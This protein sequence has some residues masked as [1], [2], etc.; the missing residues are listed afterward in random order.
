M[1]CRIC[2]GETRTVLD[3]GA[4]AARQ[5]AEAGRRRPRE[6]LPARGRVLPRLRQPAAHPLRRRRRTSTTTIS[7][8]RR[9]R[10]RSR[11]TASTS[12]TT[13]RRRATSPDDAFLLEFG[14]NIGHFL[15][16]AQ[17]RV[18]R[19]LG[20]DPAKAIVEMANARGVPTV[21]DYFGPEVA[22]AT[23]AEH[24]RAQVVAGR[25]CAAHNA[26]PHALVTGARLALAPG[27][28]FVM[29][30]A[31]GLN[32]ILHGE[33]G[34]IYHEHM[35]YYTARSGAAALRRERA[36]A[37]R[38]DA[39]RHPR[40]LDG[41]LR[42]AAGDPPGAL[43]RRG[44]DRA[45]EGDPLG[46]AARPAAGDAR[47]LA[48]RDPGAARPLPGDRP[49]GLDVRRQRQGRDLRQRRRHRRGATSPSAPIRPR[50][51]SAASCPAPASRSAPRPRRSTPAPTT[52]W[53]PPGTTAT[54]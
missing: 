24:G 18:G 34:Q 17:T 47:A 6:A 32:T 19:V 10:R 28:V 37:R 11:R 51:R 35:Y 45:R 33:I 29:E 7:T 41:V 12:S 8:S 48:D 46:R 9:P 25:H 13:C 15:K 26:D 36:R 42:R 27:G 5:P 23:V 38:P 39:D 3:L 21:C 22:K 4:D 30:N 1:T 40:R 31:Y 2:R 20:I 54:S 43:D 52:T 53:S 49:L 50:R 44:D 16:Y 14:S